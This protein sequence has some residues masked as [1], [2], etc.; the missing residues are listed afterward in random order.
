MNSQ[1]AFTSR[2]AGQLSAV[3]A[4]R[5]NDLPNCVGPCCAPSNYKLDTPE[6]PLFLDPMARKSIEGPRDTKLP[7][8]LGPCCAAEDWGD[9]AAVLATPTKTPSMDWESVY[10]E[11]PNC[12][13][14]TCA[15]YGRVVSAFGDLI[16]DDSPPK[17]LPLDWEN[18]SNEM[19]LGAGY[20]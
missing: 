11:L 1:P 19:P 16:K 7:M 3:H 9:S 5:G 2:K 14:A 8:C 10:D 12:A 15:F 4:V 13:G 6:E 18:W 17:T 20:C